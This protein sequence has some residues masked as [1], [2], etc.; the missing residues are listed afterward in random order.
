MLNR[1][2]IWRKNA[3]LVSI[4][5]ILEV[6]FQHKKHAL[7]DRVVFRSSRPFKNDLIARCS[8]AYV[9]NAANISPPTTIR[10][11]L[12]RI[13]HGPWKLVRLWTRTFKHLTGL[14]NCFSFKENGRKQDQ[15]GRNYL[16]NRAEIPKIHGKDGAAIA[17]KAIPNP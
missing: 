13:I 10:P 11:N 1:T 4:M 5:T 12:V 6:F 15:L 3:V 7:L 8:E 2:Q 17:K 14:E 9:M 16:M